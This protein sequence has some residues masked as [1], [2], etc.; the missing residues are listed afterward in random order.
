RFLGYARNDDGAKRYQNSAALLIVMRRTTTPNL[1]PRTLNPEPSPS[2]STD[3]SRVLFLIFLCYNRS[4]GTEKIITEENRVL[5]HTW[6][7]GE[8]V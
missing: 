7:Q 3:E 8:P 5:H 2:K 4:H 1:E 6:L